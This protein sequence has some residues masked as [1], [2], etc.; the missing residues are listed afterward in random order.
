VS[1]TAAVFDV[2]GA[3]KRLGGRKKIYVKMLKTFEQECGRAD[4]TIRQYLT[5]DDMETVERTAHM[6][7]GAA[8]AIGATALFD[9]A[10]N[11]EKAIFDKGPEIDNCFER[12][13]NELD[14]ALEAASELLAME[15]TL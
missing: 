11:L 15:Q 12:F 14:N 8:S 7:K 5:A 1:D 10:A 6:V 13:K 9:A 4:K 3:L 2:P